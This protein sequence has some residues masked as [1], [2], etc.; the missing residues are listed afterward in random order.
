MSVADIQAKAFTDNDVAREAIEALMWPNGPVCAH[1]GC[2]GKI[3]RVEGK[4]ARP[5]L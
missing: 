3:G 1:C 4:S 2:T 5:G